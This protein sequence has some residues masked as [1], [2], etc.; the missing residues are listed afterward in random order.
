MLVCNRRNCKSKGTEEK[1][2]T[3]QSNNLTSIQLCGNIPHNDCRNSISN[4]SNEKKL[5]CKRLERK[6]LERISN[7]ISCN[8]NGSISDNISSNM[9]IIDKQIDGYQRKPICTAN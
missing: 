8:L 7:N 6:L 4:N 3:L 5:T 9:G 1:Q 2:Q